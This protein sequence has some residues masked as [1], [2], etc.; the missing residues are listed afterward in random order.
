MG[1]LRVSVN[2]NNVFS[3]VGSRKEGFEFDE[4][5]HSSPPPPQ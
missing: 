2:E 4:G 3:V 1:P 5:E